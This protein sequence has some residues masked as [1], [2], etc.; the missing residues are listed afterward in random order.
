MK[1]EKVRNIV[2]ELMKEHGLT[3]YVFKWNNS[4]RYFGVHSGRLKYIKLSRPL[5]LHESD[6]ERIVNTILH[7]IA[8]ALDY[9]NRGYS[10]HDNEWKRI[11]RSIGC[12]GQRCSSLGGVDMSEF[13]KWVVS[14][15]V[16]DFKYYR[17]RKSKKT[18]AC[19]KCCKKH[20]NGRYTEKFKLEWELNPK[21]VKTY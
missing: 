16:C 14:C 6:N 1:L 15:P 12:D 5:T 21:V 18:Q 20:N 11:A 19:G 10:C 3:G 8:H 9:K 17:A 4:V 13:M 2:I 7:E